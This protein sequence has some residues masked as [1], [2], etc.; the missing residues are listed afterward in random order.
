MTSLKPLL[1]TLRIPFLVL[2]PCC[3]LVGVGTAVWQGG[4]VNLLEVVLVL[5]AGVAAHACVNVYNEYF[6]FKSGLDSR[7]VRTPFSGGSGTL[8]ALPHLAP[9]A[10]ALA[11]AL[12]LLTALIGL[13]FL[14]VRGWWLL[15]LAALGF[16]IAY[17]YTNWLSKHPLVCLLTPGTGFGLIFVLG[18]HFA[19]TGS[20]TW[21]A[22]VAALVP[23]FLVSNLLLINQFPDVEADRTVGKKHFP[24]LIGRRKTAYIYGAFLLG[25]YLAI[26]VG[27]VLG[28][29]PW[30]T[31]LGLLT[32]PLAWRAFRGAVRFADDI[33]NLIPILG[34]NVE[35]VLLTPLLTALGLAL[36]ALVR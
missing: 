11:T 19:L 15:P 14:A 10:F 32:A 34:L 17:V 26:I 23:F 6:D 20:Y 4:P 8:Q 3:V 35:I 30:P 22:F 28:L 25:A 29:L 13:Y 24:L 12:G 27:I 21:T 1:G 2:A 33:P 36:A 18:V 16:V 7:T 5:I 9:A 31:L